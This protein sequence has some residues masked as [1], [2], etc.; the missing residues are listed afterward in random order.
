MKLKAQQVFDATLCLAAV[1][2]E[3]RPMPQKGA[4]RLAR[5]HSKLLPEF[6]VLSEKRDQLISSYDWKNDDGVLAVPPEKETEF[7][8]RWKEIAEEELEVA[9]EPV[10]LAQL[11]LG[12]AVAGSVTAAEL[13]VLGDLVAD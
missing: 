11:D 12:D 1:I 7:F 13:I 2:R 5:L 8:A 10:P 9:V 4:Y 3:N 6:N